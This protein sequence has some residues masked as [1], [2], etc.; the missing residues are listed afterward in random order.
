LVAAGTLRPDAVLLGGEQQGLT[1]TTVVTAPRKRTRV[2]VMVGFGADDGATAAA[3]LAA[4]A[5][6]CVPRR[7]RAAEL[8]AILRA[9]HPETVG[10]VEP[11]LKC[12]RLLLDPAT[13]EV[14]HNVEG[15]FSRCVSTGFCAT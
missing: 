13:M 3:V 5:T 11:A 8:I 10:M 12:G 7:Y 9:I 4:G 6:A 1:R 15:S 14:R 2:P